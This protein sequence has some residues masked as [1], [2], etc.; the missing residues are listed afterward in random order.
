MKS[1]NT[2][3]IQKITIKQSEKI[4]KKLKNEIKKDFFHSGPKLP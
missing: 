1:E 4:I 2:L 3:K